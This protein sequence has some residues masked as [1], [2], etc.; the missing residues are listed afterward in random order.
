MDSQDDALGDPHRRGEPTSVAPRF[1]VAAIR[2]A[3]E[4]AGVLLARDAASGAPVDAAA[5]P[6]ARRALDAGVGFA[7]VLR[8]LGAVPDVAALV[9][10]ARFITPAGAPRRFDTWFFV[11]AAPDGH[12]YRHDAH[13][14]VASRWIRPAAALDAHRAGTFSLVEPTVL[15]LTAVAGFSSAARLL[16]ASRAAWA[17]RLGPVTTRDARRGWVLPLPTDEPPD[18]PLASSRRKTPA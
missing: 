10:M 6:E 9:P 1:A 11:T 16:T 2:E 8:E 4:E 15:T 12:E 14:T 3:F 7:A 17:A 13:E 5:L 18:A